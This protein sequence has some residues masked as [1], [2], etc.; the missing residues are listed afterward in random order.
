MSKR[1]ATRLLSTEQEILTAH[2]NK[3]PKTID[4]MFVD[5]IYINSNNIN[6]WHFCIYEHDKT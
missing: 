5:H 3:V 6:Y 1:F 2:K 4:F